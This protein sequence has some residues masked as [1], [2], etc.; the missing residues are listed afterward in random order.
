[1][2]DPGVAPRDGN[3][4]TTKTYRGAIQT[5]GALTFEGV[6]FDHQS[7]DR[8]AAGQPSIS[9]SND[10]DPD[11]AKKAISLSPAPNRSLPLLRVDSGGSVAL[12]SDAL[13]PATTYTLKDRGIADRRLRP[14][15]RQGRH[16]NVR[17]RQLVA[18]HLGAL[19]L[20]HLSAAARSRA[21]RLRR[22][23]CRNASIARSSRTCGRRI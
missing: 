11:S 15:A 17:Y 21:R 14:A 12:D 6:G 5:Y 9:F 7:G 22:R 8:F 4:P 1:V 2:I 18:G 19:G 23:T 10:L 20:E 3:L 13:A 16:G